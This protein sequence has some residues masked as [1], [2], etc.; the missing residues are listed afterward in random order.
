VPALDSCVILV[1]SLPAQLTQHGKNTLLIRVT[2]LQTRLQHGCVINTAGTR[3]FHACFG[4]LLNT[5][6]VC[7][8]EHT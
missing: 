6:L 7:F 5:V 8:T 4:R 2:V 3:V 1:N